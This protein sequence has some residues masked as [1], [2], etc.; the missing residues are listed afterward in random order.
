MVRY[1]EWM[2]AAVYTADHRAGAMHGKSFFMDSVY[3]GIDESNVYGR[4]DF[5]SQV[6]EIDFDL[7]INL[8][9]WAAEGQR[10][11]RILRLD[12][13]VEA[14]KIR[15]WKVTAPDEDKPL[16]ASSR[17]TN[18]VAVALAR[19]FEFKLP[20]AWLLAAPV[21]SANDSAG[22]KA[23]VPVATKLRV[24]FSLWH[25]GLPADA[26]PLEGWIGLQ[27]LSEENLRSLA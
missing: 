9:S 27:L 6:P 2:G 17:P 8:E 23:T 26:L 20:L 15:S 19:N 7:V 21:A 22:N 1:F 10:P 3:A 16:A 13:D 14:G 24:R 4:L 11:R 12:V 18:E 5:I 25:N